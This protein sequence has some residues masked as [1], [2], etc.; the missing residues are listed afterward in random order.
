MRR[1]L[2]VH[3]SPQPSPPRTGH[4]PERPHDPP[5][6][7]RQDVRKNGAVVHRSAPTRGNTQVGAV[8]ADRSVAGTR[9]RRTREVNY[10]TAG[11]APF[12][13]GSK[14]ATH[15]TCDVI[16]KGSTWTGHE[17]A[18]VRGSLSARCPA[19]GNSE[20]QTSVTPDGFYSRFGTGR[21]RPNAPAA[22]D[23]RERVEFSEQCFIRSG[24]YVGCGA[25]CRYE[26]WTGGAASLREN[27]G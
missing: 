20:R 25:R 23:E 17:K 22:A 13:T 9:T 18:Q 27:D 4:S 2:W 11:Q 6:S 3:S 1:Y 7:E 19:Y 10:E 21:P 26:V 14:I 12:L 15:S 8:W 5:G 24:V 16:G